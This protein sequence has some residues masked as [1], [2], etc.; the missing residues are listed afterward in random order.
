MMTIGGRR[1][2]GAGAV[3]GSLYPNPQAAGR[4][5]LGQVWASETSKP[6]PQGHTSF[7]KATP[8]P[9]MPHLLILSKQFH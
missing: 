1:K 5:E 4:E 8:T 6:H 3:A 2:R 9:A 7:Y